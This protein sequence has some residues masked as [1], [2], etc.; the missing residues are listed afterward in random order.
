MKLSDLPG[1]AGMTRAE[2]LEVLCEVDC[3]TWAEKKRGFRNQPFHLEWYDVL[4]T[5]SRGCIVAP[6]D[7]GKSE[8]CTVNHVAHK[9]AYSPGFWS[10]VFCATKD[11]AYELKERIDTCLEAAHP[12][13]FRG[14]VRRNKTTSVYANGSRVQVAG[15]GSRVRSAHPDLII[16]D[17]VL[18]ESKC[19]TEHQRKKT[20]RWWFGTVANMAH[21]GTWRVVRG[22]GLRWFPPSRIFLVGTPFHASDL[23]LGM[24]TNGQYVFLR[25]AADF[26]EEELVPGTCAVEVIR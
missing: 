22:H 13:L 21:P 23:L 25:Y 6:R 3:A 2:K 14:R 26:L 4:Q 9:S 20:E 15:A 7:H 8:V 16:G 24:R 18:E 10:Y 11:L 19:A 1:W 12:E 17:D 5:E